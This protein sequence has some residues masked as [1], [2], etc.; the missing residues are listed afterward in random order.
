MKTVRGLAAAAVVVAIGGGLL[1][2]SADAGSIR[3]T[4]TFG[5]TVPPKVSAGGQ[6]C[7]DMVGPTGY[8]VQNGRLE[9]AVV[10]LKKVKGGKDFPASAKSIVSDQTSCVFNP[11]VALVAEGGTVTF[12]NSDTVLHNVKSSSLKNPPFNEGVEAGKTLVKT[13]KSGG[14]FVKVTC[15]VHP[16]MASWIVVMD[17]PYYAVTDANGQFVLRDVPKG[18]YKLVVWHGELGNDV[19]LTIDGEADDAGRSGVKVKLGASQDMVLNAAYKGGALDGLTPP[20]V[21]KDGEAAPAPAPKPE[22]AAKP[23]KAAKPKPQKAAKPEKA[24]KSEPKAAAKPEKAAE[25]APAA[26]DKPAP[27]STEVR[28]IREKPIVRVIEVPAGGEA[29][30]AGK[31]GH[32]AESHG[33][34]P[35]QTNVQKGGLLLLLALIA[36]LTG[37]LFVVVGVPGAAEMLQ[38]FLP[39][40]S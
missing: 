38:K 16:W 10:Y 28:V 21:G 30:D 19:K 7:P 31:M 5:G 27:T 18:K 32:G 17:H 35:I 15:S 13:F 20:P 6:G 34:K 22:A 24:A 29:H 9:G 36:G 3:G 26:A 4:V 33:I 25:P 12:K 23:E 40:K 37:P 1:A 8:S 39:K 11:H 14:E 2:E